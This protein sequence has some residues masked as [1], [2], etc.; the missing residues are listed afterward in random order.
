ME[1]SKQHYERSLA[2]WQQSD[3]LERR[4]CLLFCLSLW[5]RTYAVLHRDEYVQA[6]SQAKKY[7]QPCIEVFE[8]ANRS[9]IEAKFI[10]ALGDVLQ[11]L[12][13]EAVSKEARLQQCNELET[14]AKKALALHQRH[15]TT[16][17]RLAYA[18][19]LLA[20]VA[21]AKASWTQAQQYAEI[22]L[23]ILVKDTSLDRV[24]Q[25]HRGWYL[26]LL[27]IAQQHL[28]QVPKAIKSLET[29]RAESKPQ[30]DP[31]LYIR[32]LETLRSLYFD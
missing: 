15:P 23:Q 29:A 14:V 1:Q 13:L 11:R 20:E 4:G 10:N 8:Q 16:P 3:N 22:A 26:L 25:Y 32:I 7:Y 2:F 9:D 12:Q 18:Y 6:C 30:Y 27:A 28:G 21:V 19:G 17:V 5:W 24:R 31:P